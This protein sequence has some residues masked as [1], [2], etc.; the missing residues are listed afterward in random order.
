[1]LADDQYGKR[2]RNVGIAY[3]LWVMIATV[4]LAATG[5]MHAYAV[6]TSTYFKQAL[7]EHV[8]TDDVQVE[9]T[10]DSVAT[11]WIVAFVT[12][13]NQII[14]SYAGDVVDPWI[15]NELNDDKVAHIRYGYY[16]T[17]MGVALY[18]A[19]GWLDY[20]VFLFL[21]LKRLDFMLLGAGRR[22]RLSLLDGA[23]ALAAQAAVTS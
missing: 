18:R 19:A 3:T 21:A 5:P 23:R 16:R 9:V 12:C 10:I 2:V 11:W 13:T 6:A 14:S 8:Q 17:L 7:F 1:M 20:I 15:T 4:G 22:P